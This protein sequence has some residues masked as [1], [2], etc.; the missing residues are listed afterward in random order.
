M[1]YYKLIRQLSQSVPLFCRPH[2]TKGPWST[3]S[4]KMDSDGLDFTFNLESWSTY[5]VNFHR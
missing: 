1:C 2:N 3:S 5:L 4:V